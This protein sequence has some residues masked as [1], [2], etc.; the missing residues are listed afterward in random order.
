MFR[1]Y[2]VQTVGGWNF[3]SVTMSD[4]LVFQN[5]THLVIMMFVML[6][7]LSGNSIY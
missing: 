1:L 5:E 2:I 4:Y 3:S 6:L 7:M